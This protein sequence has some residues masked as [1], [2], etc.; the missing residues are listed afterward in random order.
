M[1][2]ACII[3]S[4]T[5]SDPTPGP[6]PYGAPVAFFEPAGD[7]ELPRYITMPFTDESTG[8]PTSWQWFVNGVLAAIT[9]NFSYYF[10]NEGVYAIQLVVHNAYGTDSIV[11]YY[12]INVPPP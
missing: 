9:Q 5:G 1:I 12:Y 6:P 7:I 3:A 8:S 2:A 10:A 4:G 11:Q